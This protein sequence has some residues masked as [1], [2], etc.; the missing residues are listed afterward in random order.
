[1]FLLL[2]IYTMFTNSQ[3]ELLRGE[4]Y[5]KLHRRV[6]TVDGYTESD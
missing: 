5:R 6:L 1:M 2:P 3:E 4:S